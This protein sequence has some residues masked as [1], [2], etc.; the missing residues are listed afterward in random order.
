MAC[1]LQVAG[2]TCNRLAVYNPSRDFYWHKTFHH[3]L[4]ANGTHKT[5]S[6]ETKKVNLLRT[7]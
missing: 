3:S 6:K 2:P 5:P 7:I 1:Y 4:L